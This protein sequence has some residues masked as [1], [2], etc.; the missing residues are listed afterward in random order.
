MD[1]VNEIVLNVV[2]LTLRLFHFNLTLTYIYLVTE[3]V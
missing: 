3:A 1:F 2:D